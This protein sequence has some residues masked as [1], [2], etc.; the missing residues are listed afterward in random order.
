MKHKLFAS[1]N[2]SRHLYTEHI[3]AD[4]CGCF[5]R[6]DLV[7]RAVS[8][9]ACCKGGGMGCIKREPGKG[10]GEAEEEGPPTSCVA[11][12][13]QCVQSITCMDEGGRGA[14][15]LPTNDAAGKG[16]PPTPG[17]RNGADA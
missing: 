15:G 14:E 10:G 4:T 2:E 12:R 5:T 6:D 17:A 8:H 9:P 13:E 7:K 16:D 11:L 3:H 1:R